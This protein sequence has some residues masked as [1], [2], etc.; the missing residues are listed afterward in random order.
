MG[1]APGLLRGVGAL[2]LPQPGL[3][4]VGSQMGLGN[5]EPILD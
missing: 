2:E 1:A 5:L 4:K 3:E